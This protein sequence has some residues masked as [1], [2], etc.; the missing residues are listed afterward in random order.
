MVTGEATILTAPD[1]PP[2]YTPA[3]SS[4]FLDPLAE[5]AANLG[6]VAYAT[7]EAVHAPPGGYSFSPDLLVSISKKWQDL[8]KLFD[9]SLELAEQIETTQGP[10]ADYASA[11]HAEKV[12]G[13]GGA[14]WHMLI[15]RRDYC[16][17]QAEKFLAAAG[18]Y[19]EAETRARE[20][21]ENQEGGTL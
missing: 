8:A 1:R 20:E 7:G 6:K 19:G 16:Q 5:A 15:V 2:P 14:L 10:G 12:R 4:G 21:L 3:T 18:Q 9:D 17:V 11:G 13:T